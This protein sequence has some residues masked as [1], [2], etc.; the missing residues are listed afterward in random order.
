[1]AYKRMSIKERAKSAMSGQRS[2]KNTTEVIVEK[3]MEN[4]RR[5]SITRETTQKQ[6]LQR[7][8]TSIQH[9]RKISTANRDMVEVPTGVSP[10][11]IRRSNNYEDMG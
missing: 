11:D 4:S 8:I 5:E 6:K 10:R 9:S 3:S 7:P 1:M 2:A